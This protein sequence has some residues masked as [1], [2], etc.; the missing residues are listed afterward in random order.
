M[1]G[2]ANFV[3][4]GLILVGGGVELALTPKVRSLVNINYLRF[5][6]TD[7]IR[8]LLVTDHVDGEI[9]VDL[10]LGLQYR[11]LLTDNL[12]ISA[13]LGALLPGNGLQDI[14]ERSAQL[15]Y[16]GSPNGGANSPLLGGLLAITLTY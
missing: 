1:E 10:S 8:H 12:I 7:S 5:A 9:G 6:A 11:P 15:A 2:Q 13:G 4:P 16:R 14:Y 3:N